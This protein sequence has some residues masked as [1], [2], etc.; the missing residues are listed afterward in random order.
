MLERTPCPI[1]GTVYG[2]VLNDRASLERVDGELQRPPYKRAPQAPAM[3]IKPVN[4]LVGSGS[5]VRLPLGESAI[6]IGTTLGIVFGR[7]ASRLRASESAST[8][9]GVALAADL[10]LPHTS[11]YRPAIREKCFDGACPVGQIAMP[12]AVGALEK[13]VLHTWVDERLVDERRLADLI[14]DVPSLVADVSEFMTLRCDDMLLVGVRYQAPSTA[15]G[16]HVRIAANEPALG[17]LEFSIAAF[18]EQQA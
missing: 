5:T 7:S 9:G 6:E 1:T 17:S 10:S 14:R 13:L 4:T 15:A 2:V 12:D 3:Y 11:Y 8:I 18:E 16:A